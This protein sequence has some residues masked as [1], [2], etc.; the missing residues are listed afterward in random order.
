MQVRFHL[1]LGDSSENQPGLTEVN[2]NK[3]NV[4]E[5]NELLKSPKIDIPVFRREVTVTGANYQWLQ[6]HIQTRNKNLD[7][8]VLELLDIA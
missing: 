5:L 4:A 1:Q 3:E 8:R 6:K 7:S 2:L